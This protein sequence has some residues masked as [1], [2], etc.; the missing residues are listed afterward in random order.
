MGTQHCY[1]VACVLLSVLS[2]ACGQCSPGYNKSSKLF[3][4]LIYREKPFI[5]SDAV[6][7]NVTTQRFDSLCGGTPCSG[8]TG[9][10]NRGT[11]SIGTDTGNGANVQVS[12][13]G[14]NTETRFQW[15]AGSVP[16]SF[17]ICSVT[18]YAGDTQDSILSCNGNNAGHKAW[19][20]GHDWR[21]AG[22][23]FYGHDNKNF[24]DILPVSTFKHNYFE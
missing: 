4:D 15:G 20:H 21:K 10:R 5:V 3:D 1:L 11:V 18:R 22:V 17:T 8:N 2:L 24:D 7:W 16:A 13:V 6:D 14:G 9:A 19:I 23:H 12:Y